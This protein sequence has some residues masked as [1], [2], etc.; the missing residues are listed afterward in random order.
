VALVRT[1]VSDKHI[2]IIMVE[3]ISELG[4]LAVTTTE[5]HWEEI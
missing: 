4:T 2:T 5:A 1:Y 3:R